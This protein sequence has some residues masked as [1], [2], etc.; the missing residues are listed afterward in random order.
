MKSPVI[1][2]AGIV[3]WSVL[4]L[5]LAFTLWTN[6]GENR[7]RLIT[8]L[9]DWPSIRSGELWRIWTPAFLHFSA[10]GSAIFHILFNGLWWLLLGGLIESTRGR[11]TLLRFFLLTAAFS[12]AVAW[13]AYGPLFGGLSGVVYALVGYVWLCGFRVPVWRAAMPHNLMAF[14][15]IFMLLGWTGWLGNIANWAHAAGLFI[16]LLS[17]AADM[18]W[19]NS[20]QKN[21]NF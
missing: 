3:T 4:A 6:F 15:V 13:W 12:N 1:A 7:L 5:C 18:L 14:F 2:R 11:G 10:W 17:A 19:T 8:W 16:G 20:T 9:F 21:S